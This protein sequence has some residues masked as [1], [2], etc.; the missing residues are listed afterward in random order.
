MGASALQQSLTNTEFPISDYPT[1]SPDDLLG[2]ALVHVPQ[3]ASLR[4]LALAT[5]SLDH[6]RARPSAESHGR[7][8]P[9]GITVAMAITVD[10]EQ[11]TALG[12]EPANIELLTN[13]AEVARE[14]VADSVAKQDANPNH[15]FSKAESPDLLNTELFYC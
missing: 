8:R 12:L 9:E 13:A 14:L 10:R 11:L 4:G 15:S 6:R 5:R 2:M 7:P 3:L 1:Y